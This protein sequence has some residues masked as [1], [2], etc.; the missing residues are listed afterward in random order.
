M[1]GLLLVCGE[2]QSIRGIGKRI[3]S[4]RSKD[5]I[6]SHTLAFLYK[7][8]WLGNKVRAREKTQSKPEISLDA[9]LG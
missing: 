3:I 7:V 2:I 8:P 5:K 4:I 9:P 1:S 6:N